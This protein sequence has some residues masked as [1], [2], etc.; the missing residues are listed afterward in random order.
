MTRWKKWE[1]KEFPEN[2]VESRMLQKNEKMVFQSSFEV[3]LAGM[4]LI[5]EVIKMEMKNL[6]HER[7]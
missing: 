1:K 3:V 6:R 2:Q 5:G 4:L 7:N